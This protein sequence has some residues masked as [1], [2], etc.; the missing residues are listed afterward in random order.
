MKKSEMT[1]TAGEGDNG[2]ATSAPSEV[3]PPA[4]G[5]DSRSKLSGV[6][7]TIA[8]TAGPVISAALRPVGDLT[9]GALRAIEERRGARVRR[10]RRQGRAP[11]LNLWEAHPEA[12]RAS[13]RELGLRAVSV[14][15]I[16][17]TAVEGPTQRG[18][19]FLPLRQL[20]GRDWRARWQ[21]ILNGI[22][23]LSTLPPVELIKFGDQYWVVDGHN[24]V[25][26]ALYTGQVEIDANVVEMRL[27]GMPSER[28]TANLA[29]F[30]EGS[31]DLRE[32]G[33]GRFTRTSVRPTHVVSGHPLDEHDDDPSAEPGHAHDRRGP[34]A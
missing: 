23:A 8:D 27:P 6:A 9:T 1:P 13:M 2:P 29:S 14:E 17:G 28:A 5:G 7:H 4:V 10:A 21:R 11:L 26:A 20:R 12:H 18:G 3:K 31:R 33:Q 25:A 30:L 15:E 16:A 24:R 32:A 19:D 22:E 34:E